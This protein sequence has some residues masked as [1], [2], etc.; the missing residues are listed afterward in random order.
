MITLEKMCNVRDIDVLIAIVS[1]IRPGAANRTANLILPCEPKVCRRSITPIPSLEGVL[2]C[3]FGVVA[4][5]EHI[6]QI[7][8]AFAEHAGRPGRHAAAG[9]GEGE[10]GGD[11]KDAARILGLCGASSGGRNRRSRRSGAFSLGFRV[12]PFVGR[13]VPLMALKPTKPRI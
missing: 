7:C 8:E 10:S 4:Y 11:R 13:T 6:L 3:T 5:E 2:R 1:V 12:M 9:S